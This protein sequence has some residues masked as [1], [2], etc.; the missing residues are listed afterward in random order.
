MTDEVFQLICG[1]I[2][3]VFHERNTMLH[4]WLYLLL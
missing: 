2:L 4:Y 1:L 3:S